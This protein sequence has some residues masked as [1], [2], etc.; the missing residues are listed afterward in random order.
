MAGGSANDLRAPYPKGAQSL[1]LIQAPLTVVA[2]KTKDF[3]T[4]EMTVPFAFKAVKATYSAQ[5]IN[6]TNGITVNIQDDS[7]TPQELVTDK[8][9]TAITGGA[10]TEQDLSVDKTI[11]INAGA[12]LYFSYGSGASDDSLDG[13]INLWVRPVN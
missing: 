7:S 3:I 10:G 6:V 4:H 9:V 13:M 5:D 8:A 12:V 2:S 11:T 1:V